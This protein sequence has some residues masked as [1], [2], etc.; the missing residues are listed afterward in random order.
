[1]SRC[2]HTCWLK[3]WSRG[4]ETGLEVTDRPQRLL[5][6]FDN[7]TSE[8]AGLLI[9]VGNQSKQAAFR[10]LTFQ[11]ER[12]H[13]KTG[14]EVHLL[15]SLFR[16][17]RCQRVVIADT[18]IPG[19]R[20]KPP[21]L[22][23]NQCHE[24]KVYTDMAQPVAGEPRCSHASLLHKI[25]FP[26]ADVICVFV[27]DLG[28]FS[29]S[30]G[31]LN[32]WLKRGAPSSS[33]VRPQILLVVNQEEKERH[34]VV[35]QRFVDETRS[36]EL[37]SCFRGITLVGVPRLSG[38]GRRK[39]SNP[40]PGL[41]VRL[42]P[43]TSRLRVLS[44]D[45]GG[46]RGS[47]PIGFLKSIQDEIGI[48]GYKVQR[49]FDVKIGTSSGALS[50]ISL[51]VLGWSVDD[52]MSHLKRFAKESFVRRCPDFLLRLCRLPFVSSVVWLLQLVYALLADSKYAADGLERL[53]QDTYGSDRCITDLSTA[54]AMGTYVGVTLTKARD[55]S[56]FLATNYNGTDYRHLESGDGQKLVKWWEVLRCATAAPFYFAPKRIGDLGVFQDGGLAVNN[57]ACIAV[58]EAISLGSDTTE[59]SIVV[60]LGT[61]S[62]VQDEHDPSSMLSKFPGKE[63]LLDEVSKMDHVQR[64]AR[65][66][67]S[68][69]SDLY[70]L[71]R[72]LRAELFLFALDEQSLPY[73]ANGGYHCTGH[74]TCRLRAQTPEYEAFINQLCERE[75]SFQVGAQIL[76][77]T[78]ESIEEDLSYRVH[79]VVPSLSSLISI[80]LTEETGERFDVSGSPFTL[81]WLV[82]RQELD[83]SFGTS[84][85]RK[86][87]LP[88]W[89]CIPRAKRARF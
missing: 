24:V 16:E 71:C 15:T 11:T 33:P 4:V 32:S 83:A 8:T 52:C 38:R 42:T 45:G 13:A 65:D 59:P 22:N 44:V 41:S 60:S 62:T 9:L 7:P 31:Q 35:L 88:G 76:R 1:M 67:A 79:F 84:D 17:F 73:F 72:H 27:N 36:G 70:Q 10:K 80:T 87:K 29:A 77:V 57:P 28:G 61:G 55:G 51:D 6:D 63:P 34:Q 81:E 49:N 85:H 50:V 53:L 18:D 19:L 82:Q 66:A 23:G 40:P 89:T 43:D 12:I 21:S 69:T 46:I 68:G 56:V 86:R 58:R 25:L 75:A 20:L 54:T 5:R 47:A 74:I 26:S 14:G 78:R 48:P 39:R 37:T 30:L 2:R 3:P 64:T